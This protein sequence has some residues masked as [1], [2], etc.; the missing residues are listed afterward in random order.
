MTHSVETCK[1]I[2]RLSDEIFSLECV[3]HDLGG[4]YR[5]LTFSTSHFWK[6]IQV[7]GYQLREVLLKDLATMR[8]RLDE[9]C[10]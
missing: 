6:P 5:N 2:A 1:Q 10:K 3:V 7:K 4:S 8:T 9:L